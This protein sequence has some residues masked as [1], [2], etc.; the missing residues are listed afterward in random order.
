MVSSALELGYK[1][2]LIAAVL[3]GMKFDPVV[4]AVTLVWRWLAMSL[5]PQSSRLLIRLLLL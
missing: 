3:S 5:P 4:V 2:V 1:P